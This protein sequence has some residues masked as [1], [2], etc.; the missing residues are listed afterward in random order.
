MAD[1]LA[2]GVHVSEVFHEPGFAPDSLLAACENRGVP[3]FEVAP[4][5]L[6]STL[7]TSSPPPVA[8]VAATSVLVPVD[9][10]LD[11][12][13]ER[14]AAV[15]VLVDVS[16][17]GN[18]GTLLRAAEAA[19]CAGVIAV[20]HGVDLYNP[21]VVRASAGSLFR[22]P[23]ADS[24]DSDRVF[25]ALA[26]RSVA[27][28]ATVVSGGTGHLDAALDDALGGAC[29]IWLGNEAHGMDESDTGRC[30]LRVTIEMAP[31]PESLNVAMAGTVLCFEA[32][33]RRH[34]SG[35]AL[36]STVPFSQQSQQS[37][38]SQQSQQSQQQLNRSPSRDQ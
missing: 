36:A 16:D 8:A 14:S 38:H 1:A 25:A 13:V 35:G 29:A 28:V 21:K 3:V 17:P 20:G 9:A 31:G 27:S 34:A 24:P 23:L 22:L 6:G 2:A 32:F 33:R 19:G 10:V 30:E 37:M 18:V 4:G 26:A 15:L 5:V 7:A 12:A 11:A